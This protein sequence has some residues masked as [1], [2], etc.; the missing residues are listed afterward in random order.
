M[1]RDS[2]AHVFHLARRDSVMTTENVDR[3]STEVMGLLVLCWNL[4]FQWRPSLMV[5]IQHAFSQLS[6]PP[7]FSP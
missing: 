2:S 6:I 7:Q 5:A 4:L 3:M 1:G